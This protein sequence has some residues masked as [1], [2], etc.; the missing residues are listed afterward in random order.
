M[1]E[2]TDDQMDIVTTQPVLPSVS[3]ADWAARTEVTQL[4][5]SN[6]SVL[7]MQYLILGGYNDAAVAL[8]EV[9][10]DRACVVVTCVGGGGVCVCELTCNFSFG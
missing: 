10:H 5:T 2:S 7:L 4:G 8:A 1:A 6:F 3:E 9:R